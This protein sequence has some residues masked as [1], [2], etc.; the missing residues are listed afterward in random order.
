MASM[1]AVNPYTGPSA[2]NRVNASAIDGTAA[3]SAIAKSAGVRASPNAEKNTDIVPSS[4]APA[5]DDWQAGRY[6]RVLIVNQQD[7]APLSEFGDRCHDILKVT[8]SGSE[9]D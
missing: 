6:R 3:I 4:L 1:R 9:L 2:T 8:Q 5:P 7:K